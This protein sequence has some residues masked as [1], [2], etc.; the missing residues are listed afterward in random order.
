MRKNTL[1]L[2]GIFLLFCALPF[3][4]AAEETDV[5]ASTTLFSPWIGFLF[6]VFLV[7]ALVIAA[8]AIIVK[9]PGLHVPKKIRHKVIDQSSEVQLTHEAEEL[10]LKEKHTPLQKE[11]SEEQPKTKLEEKKN[12]D[13]EKPVVAEKKEESKEKESPK[14]EEKEPV[15]EEPKEVVEEKREASIQTDKPVEKTQTTPDFS[16]EEPVEQQTPTEEEVSKKQHTFVTPELDL[17][18]HHKEETENEKELSDEESLSQSVKNLTESEKPP[19]EDDDEEQLCTYLQHVKDSGYNKD[20][21]IEHLV[22]KGW[23]KEQ[24]HYCWE[25]I[26]APTNNSS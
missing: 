8:V 18:L 24:I 23:K 7:A 1:L 15:T 22:E 20:E 25:K 4:L 14:K 17:S 11:L 5:V 10:P 21:F 12:L 2:T 26:I 9:K 16:K 3:V 19:F 13:E 6:V